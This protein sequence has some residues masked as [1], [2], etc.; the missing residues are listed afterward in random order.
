[1]S[2]M[3]LMSLM[4]LRSVKPVTF[5]ETR[6]PV[7]AAVLFTVALFAVCTPSVAQQEPRVV[8]P[9][10]EGDR[11]LFIG[12]DLTQQM[13]Y[14]RA[15]ATAFLTL[16]PDAGLRFFNGGKDGATPQSCAEWVDDLLELT[17]PT[18]V[19]MLFGFNTEPT[20]AALAEFAR[21]LETLARHVRGRPGVRHV[22]LLGPPPFQ[23]GLAP[24]DGSNDTAINQTLARVNDAAA[25]VA[26]DGGL[27]FI[28]LFAPM[29]L[30]YLE[31]LRV[32]GE[33]LSLNGRHPS[34]AA[35]VVMASVILHGLAVDAPS[36]DR[37]G[38]SPLL[39][40]GMA[41]IRPALA[42]P[43]KAPSPVDAERSRTLYLSL[44]NYD[45]AFFR[46]WRLGA[47][48]RGSPE[49]SREA[50]LSEAEGLWRGI[51]AL[52]LDEADA[53]DAPGA[54]ASADQAAQG[55]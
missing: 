44:L 42:I 11:I 14:D 29:R 54:P 5:R 15:V 39:P 28:E 33:P 12:D 22:I 45:Q 30:V 36:F 46:A 1:M 35:H 25:E 48:R 16:Y 24:G 3:S 53:A 13:Y 17:R 37:I 6:G 4:P 31:G 41:R 26:Q 38:W 10:L 32:G 18:V 49:R 9:F 47:R 52:I 2:L 19:F 40:L 34:E 27:G 20:D 51:E 43:S 7:C 23:E 50:M 55:G 8:G 21:S